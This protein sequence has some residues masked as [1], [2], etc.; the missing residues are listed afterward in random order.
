MEEKLSESSVKIIRNPGSIVSDWSLGAWL[1]TFLL[2]FS[3]LEPFEFELGS[4]I[5]IFML[6]YLF[7][8]DIITV[9]GMRVFNI[10]LLIFLKM[11]LAFQEYVF[12]IDIFLKLEH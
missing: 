2:F 6:V 8:L 1:T 12:G 4:N 7:C 5:L 10:S 9:S 11:I 3:G